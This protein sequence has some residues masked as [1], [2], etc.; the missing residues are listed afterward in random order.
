VCN[1]FLEIE[2]EA[3][4]LLPIPPLAV[5]P[6]E[7][8][9]TS[10]GGHFW[11]EDETCL[12]WLDAQAP[13]SVIY[14]AFG[15]LTVFDAER[16]QELTDGL[17]LTG[18]PFLWVVRPNF[19]DGV[20]GGWLDE[21]RRRVA[22]MGLVVGWAPQQRVLS[23]PSV[24]CFVS[25]CGWNSTME[26][27]R[28]GVLALLRR[29]V[30][31]PG[32]HLRRVGHRLEDP[33]RRAGGRQQGGDQGQGGAAARRRGDQGEGAV[34]ADRGMRQRRGWRVLASGSAQ[35]CEPAKRRLVF[36]MSVNFLDV[37]RSVG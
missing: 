6:L 24:A 11:A 36:S 26:G 25:H 5:G 30:P 16:L 14:V 4:A 19:A 37:Q 29:P 15:S 22:G 31:E 17:E 10:A 33:R 28:H 3:L 13:G 23:H 2:S 7:A 18:R 1:T 35:T 9:S 34:L 27:V 20:S 21:F 8:P 32:L 12:P